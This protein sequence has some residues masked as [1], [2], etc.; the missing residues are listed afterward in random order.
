MTHPHARQLAWPRRTCRNAP[1]HVPGRVTNTPAI[2]QQRRT[3]CTLFAQSH[4]INFPPR[5][6]FLLSSRQCECVHASVPADC[7]HLRSLW[8]SPRCPASSDSA[9]VRG[10][11]TRIKCRSP[12]CGASVLTC[13]WSGGRPLS[14]RLAGG[15]LRP[16]KPT[17]SLDLADCHA[18]HS[19]MPDGPALLCERDGRRARTSAY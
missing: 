2:Q 3:P 5:M 4:L 18:C 9:A 13:L 1:P 12:L 7:K 14:E 19:W 15:I 10:R 8:P 17:W 6:R 16:Q 11:T